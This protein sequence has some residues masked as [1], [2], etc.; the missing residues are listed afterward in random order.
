MHIKIDAFLIHVFYWYFYN[1]YFLGKPKETY[2]RNLFENEEV[3]IK[4]LHK[5]WF[6]IF[7]RTRVWKLSEEHKFIVNDHGK[8]TRGALTDSI[9]TRSKF[10]ISE[11]LLFIKSKYLEGFMTKLRLLRGPTW[12][13][14]HT[15]HLFVSCILV[16]A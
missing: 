10:Y 15:Y 12:N 13:H 11:M 5:P 7:P 1:F 14:Y 9:W 4:I 3:M 8:Q 2:F 6:I 16:H